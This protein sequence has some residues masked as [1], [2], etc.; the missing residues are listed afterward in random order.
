MNAAKYLLTTELE[1]NKTYIPQCLQLWQ[2]FLDDDSRLYLDENSGSLL[3]L[4]ALHSKKDLLKNL[5]QTSLKKELTPFA[6]SDLR[7]ELLE[8]KE[9]VVPQESVLPSGQYVQLRHI[10]VPLN[11]HNEYLTWRN[12]T[13]FPHVK[14]LPQVQ[15]FLAYHSLLSTAPGVMFVSSFSCSPEEYL[16]GFNNPAYQ[17]IVKQA[18]QR[19][20]TGGAKGLFTKI[21]KK[22]GEN[23]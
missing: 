2:K 5:N 6:N 7:Q 10:E 15:S 8:F 11:V 23:A 13:I 9:T 22:Q 21:Y 4:K 19:F 20:I 3:Q 12:Q 18:G 17:E 14:N 16:Q 1:V